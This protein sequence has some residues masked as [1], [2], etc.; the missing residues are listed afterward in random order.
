ML[1]INDWIKSYFCIPLI[2]A[3]LA[4]TSLKN[5]LIIAIIYFYAT[6][7]GFVI[8]NYFDMEIDKNINQKFNKFIEI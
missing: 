3:F 2:G 4:N 7:Y 1:R 8:N 6:G 5:F